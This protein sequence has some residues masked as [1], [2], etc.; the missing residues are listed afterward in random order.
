M[1][2][3]KFVKIGKTNFRR[4]KKRKKKLISLPIV[5]F[6]LILLFG[7]GAVLYLRYEKDAWRHM[8]TQQQVMKSD[9]TVTGKTAQ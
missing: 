8:D 2:T 4:V 7:V 9:A 3:S 6:L 5:L 1:V